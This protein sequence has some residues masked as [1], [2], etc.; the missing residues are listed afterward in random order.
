MHIGGIK[1]H[2]FNMLANIYSIDPTPG[3]AAPTLIF[4]SGDV[5]PSLSQHVSV[6]HHLAVLHHCQTFTEND[7][8]KMAN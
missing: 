1:C 7:T 5:Q 3:S 8:L 4:Q 6:P 2:F